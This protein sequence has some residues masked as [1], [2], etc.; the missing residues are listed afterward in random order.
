MR[1]NSVS[2]RVPIKALLPLA[3]LLAIGPPAGASAKDEPGVHTDPGS[4]AGKEYVIPL[5][6][7]RR[8]ASGGTSGHHT[9]GGGSAQ[10]PLF[11]AGIRAQPTGGG[12]RGRSGHGRK[13]GRK[14]GKTEKTRERITP[15][16]LASAPASASTESPA[17][18]TG[19][20][21]LAIL[22]AGAG[23]G[24]LLRRGLRS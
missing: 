8:E 15:S 3:A 1:Y 18:A 23:L 7:A 4:P 16:T 11:G 22:L 10:A 17:L 5:E 6:G 2:V 9:G 20:I 13:A 19:A 24:L 14:Q 12:S 21:A